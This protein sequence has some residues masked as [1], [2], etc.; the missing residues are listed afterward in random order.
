MEIVHL[1]SGFDAL[2]LNG[3]TAPDVSLLAELEARKAEARV[4]AR[5]TVAVG[6]ADFEISHMGL[7]RWPFRLDHNRGVVAIGT[8]QALP[9]VHVEPYASFIHSDGIV[10]ALNWFR[11]RIESLL[12]EVKW[13]ATRADLF[14]DTHGLGL[15]DT[16]RELFS[17]RSRKVATYHEGER[18]TG[19]A[20]G[21]GGKLSARIYDKTAE[22]ELK[23]SGAWW[24]LVWGEQ[25]DNS[26]AVTR[27]EFQLLQPALK[28]FDA[29]DPQKLFESAAG[30]WAHLTESWLTLR[31]A[32]DDTNR[33]RWPV[34][35]RWTQVSKAPL[36]HDAVAASRM[37]KVEHARKI[38]SLL[39]GLR[40]SLTQFGALLGVSEL[41]DVTHRLERHLR[42]Q[43]GIRGTTFEDEVRSKALMLGLAL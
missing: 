18:M 37:T 32:G 21:Q 40:G 10:P 43:D 1:A 36:R 11:E 4:G 31:K 23:G 17:C 7:G 3:T 39:P 30:I 33:S 42:R 24:P 5:V 20:F 25:F 22:I 14:A 38:E 8:G 9:A 41:C 13:T 35:S 6:D 2:Y 12:G 16:D 27:V 34:D 29:V 28:Q 15:V 26:L 19:F